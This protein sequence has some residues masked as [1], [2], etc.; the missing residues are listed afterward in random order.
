MGYPIEYGDAKEIFKEIR[1]VIP[2]YNLLGP[3]PTPP[4]PDPAAVD[5]YLK[6]GYAEDLGERYA[7]AKLAASSNGS[8]TL[9]VAQTLFH[10]GKFST[11]AK[12]LLQAQSAGCLSLNPGDAARLGLQDGDRAR[13]V[14]EQGEM[15]A[16]VK[17]LD[18]VPAGLV[19][20]PEHFD[21]EARRLLNVTLDSRTGVPYYKAARVQVARA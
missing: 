3:A 2:G 12:G 21:Q 19:W 16:T 10:S 5:R 15:T 11:K 4:K 18:R 7:L 6:G 13:V 17:L 9:L 20:F 1:S 8:L 14:N